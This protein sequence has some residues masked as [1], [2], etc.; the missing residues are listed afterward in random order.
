[1]AASTRLR[2]GTRSTRY[3]VAPIEQ[4]RVC[5]MSRAGPALSAQRVYDISSGPGCGRDAA[6]A[7]NRDRTSR[8]T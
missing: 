4:S 5:I 7:V 8:V 6:R 3:D 2:T 1:M